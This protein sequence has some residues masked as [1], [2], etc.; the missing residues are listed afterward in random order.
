M[1]DCGARAR[2][3][4]RGDGAARSLPRRPRR[5]TSRHPGTIDFGFRATVDVGRRGPLRALPRPAERRVH[6]HRVRQAR[7]TTYLF[8][9]DGEEHRLPRPEVHGRLP[10]Q[11]VE[12]ERVLR[13][14]PAEL[15]LQLPD[16]VGRA[17]EGH[18]WTLDDATQKAV[19]NSRYPAP[20]AAAAGIHV[21][22]VDRRPGP[23]GL[24]VPA[25][26]AA[27]RHP[28]APR[29]DRLRPELRPERRRRRSRSAFTTTKKSGNQ[30]FG[31]SF[32]FN[33]ANELPMQLDNRT[34]DFGAAI[35]WAKPQGMFRAGIRLLGV[36]EPVQL[37]RVGQPAPARRTTRTARCRRPARTTPAATA[38][39]TARPGA[40][41]PRSRTTP[42]PSSASWGCTSSRATP[43]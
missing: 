16:A 6:Q 21:D 28:A 22:P 10:E 7:P 17:V 20:V 24:G 13:R 4:D 33:N 37:G 14:D 32:A 38:T 23:A 3:R 1:C 11:Q 31:M 15:L 2:L 40:G 42:W 26:G 41:S 39:A 9:V 30:P 35:E 34:N 29:H 43:R 27:L 19:Q 8:G 18:S 5:A 36:L 12:V 25:A